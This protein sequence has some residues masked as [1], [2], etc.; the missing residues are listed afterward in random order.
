MIGFA[1]LSSSLYFS[2]HSSASGS[3]LASIQSNTSCT[4]ASILLLS[5]SSILFASLSSSLICWRKA[6]AKVSRATL[7]SIFSLIFLSS[8]AKSSA[9]LT[10][11]SISSGE[12]LPLSLVMVI[13]SLMPASLSLADTCRIPFS[14]IS[15]V[16]SILGLPRGAGGIPF[17]SNLPS[18]LLSL[19]LARSPSKTWINS[20]AWFSAFVE[21]VLLFFAGIGVLRS[22]SLVMMPPTVSI[23]MDNAQTSTKSTLFSTSSFPVSTAACTVAPYATASSGLMPLLGSF[24]LKN[25]FNNCC[26]LGIRVEPP[27]NTTSLTSLGSILPCLSTSLTGSSVFLKRSMHSSSNLALVIFSLK[28]TPS[29]MLSTSTRASGWLDSCRFAFSHARF[30]RAV[31]FASSRISTPCFFF[32]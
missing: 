16:T 2:L 3:L 24:P 32:N 11:R 17:S 19:V 13:C 9:S 15:N 1:V 6:Y 21:N 27:T 22:I 30:S 26:T 8:I 14:S 12:R 18:I 23:P 20:V 10:I 25:S 31:A 28:S 4:A 29:A 5:S 7:S